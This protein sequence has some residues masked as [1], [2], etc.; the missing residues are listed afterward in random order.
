MTR[1]CD[2]LNVTDK[3]MKAYL[4]ECMQKQ[5]PASFEGYNSYVQSAI[6]LNK[7]FSLS[8]KLATAVTNTLKLSLNAISFMLIVK[9]VQFLVDKITELANA[10]KLASENA[11]ELYNKSN[12]IVQQN[13]EEANSL[14]ELISKYKELKDNGD[15]D[16]DSRKEIKE[17]QNDIADLV[18]TQASNLDLVN[19]KLDEELEKLNKISEEEAKRALQNAEANYYN[20]KDAGDKAV[21]NSKVFFQDYDYSGKVE[22]E[23]KKILEKAGFGIYNSNGH[24]T[25][26]SYGGFGQDGIMG[27]KMV[28][29]AI[30]DSAKEKYDYLQQLISVLEE[31]GQ[32]NTDI[33]KGLITQAAEYDKYL[34][35]EQSA[36]TDLVDAWI[37]YN[38]ISNENLKKINVN[39]VESFEKYRQKM[40]KELQ[41]D[42]SIGELI[43]NGLLSKDD[44]ET[45]VND[46]MSTASQFSDWYK[47]WKGDILDSDIDVD[48]QKITSITEAL[49]QSNGTEDGT[50][51]DDIEDYKEKLSSLQSYLEKFRDGSYT[52]EDLLSLADEFNIIGDTAEERIS[53]VAALMQ[54]ETKKAVAIIDSIIS[55]GNLDD[56]TIVDLNEYKKLLQDICDIDL[57]GNINFDLSG[58][59]LADVQSL[60]Q[61]LDQL[62]K[63]YADILDKEAFDF[64]SILNNDSFKEAFSA[65][66]E[67]YDNFI[68]TVS[69]S[70]DDINACQ[71]AFNKTTV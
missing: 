21:G 33:Y 10:E 23:A 6:N 67:E 9:G 39:S 57:N 59:A 5:V 37:N 53:K 69:K 45:S 35:N 48:T 40:L 15:L 30:G 65:Y 13:K 32:R 70:P 14:T 1:W 29:K 68:N 8:A 7:Q 71:E 55:A 18:G 22:P 34:D 17:I 58:N 4:S 43:S 61:G 16:L 24:L 63:I 51:A 36:A 38:Q 52:P 12:D 62:D 49:S 25:A 46:F 41:N 60:S 28:V 47:Q 44:L 19:G 50:W 42:E 56:A 27:S 2:G 64:S 20:A 3:T 31:N 11:N 54:S 26:P 66:T